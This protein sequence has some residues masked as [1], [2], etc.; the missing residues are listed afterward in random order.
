MI[1]L[2]DFTPQN[3]DNIYDFMRPLW[4]DT[5]GEILPLEQIE[6]LLEK[7]FSKDGLAHYRALGY[8]YQKIGD[9]GVLVT[10]EK[11]DEI[12]IDK[13]Y[14]L[15]SARGKN[16]PKEVF[17]KLQ[18]SGKDL[19]LNVNRANERAVKCYLKNGFQIER[20]TEILLDNGMINCDYEMRLKAKKST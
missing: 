19:T 16:I 18:N 14:L 6:F 9:E 4:L 11:E 12:Y 3:Y 10:V 17:D 8:R 1:K 7:Y 13:L 5:Y 2:L 20:E 15:P